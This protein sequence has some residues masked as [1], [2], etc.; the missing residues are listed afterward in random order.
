MELGQ[1][2][3][4]LKITMLEFC[5]TTKVLEENA[6]DSFYNKILGVTTIPKAIKQ[7][8]SKFEYVRKLKTI[9]GI[10]QSHKVQ[11]IQL[12][13]TILDSLRSLINP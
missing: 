11:T 3:N 6:G 8:I 13:K 4:L 5:K 12:V 2:P 7:K 10:L 1:L 9:I